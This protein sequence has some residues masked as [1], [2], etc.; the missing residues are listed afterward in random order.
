MQFV[1]DLIT[2]LCS[3]VITT[4]TTMVIIDIKNPPATFLS[5]EEYQYNIDLN[6]LLSI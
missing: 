6:L 1:H 2:T 3:Y 5:D 4:T